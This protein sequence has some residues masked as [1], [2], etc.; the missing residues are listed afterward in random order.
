MYIIKKFTLKGYSGKIIHNYGVNKYLY[1]KYFGKYIGI[2]MHM[3]LHNFYKIYEG[4]DL[5]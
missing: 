5:R 1:I 2:I 3:F 4:N